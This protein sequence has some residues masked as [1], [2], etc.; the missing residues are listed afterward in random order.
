MSKGNESLTEGQRT[1]SSAAAIVSNGLVESSGSGYGK[2]DS[3]QGLMDGEVS[4]ETKI[5]YERAS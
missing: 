4:Y 5:T 1:A 2:A 3:R